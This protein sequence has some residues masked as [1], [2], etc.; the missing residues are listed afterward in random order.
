MSRLLWVVLGCIALQ[1]CATCCGTRCPVPASAPAVIAV[2]CQD[3]LPCGCLDND[4]RNY[5]VTRDSWCGSKCDAYPVSHRKSN[6][7]CGAM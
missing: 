1:G 4:K 6:V 5:S 2:V 7:V 3:G